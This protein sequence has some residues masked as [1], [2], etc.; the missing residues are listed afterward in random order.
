[1]IL[2]SLKYSRISCSLDASENDMLHSY[3]DLKKEAKV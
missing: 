3:E 2:N 1:M